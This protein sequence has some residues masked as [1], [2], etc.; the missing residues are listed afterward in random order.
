MTEPG[1]QSASDLI[2]AAQAAIPANTR[3]RLGEVILHVVG[4][5]EDVEAPRPPGNKPDDRASV[6]FSSSKSAFAV[7][8]DA[9]TDRA[10]EALLAWLEETRSVD[11]LADVDGLLI[12]YERHPSN[13]DERYTAK[14]PKWSDSTVVERLR[15]PLEKLDDEA[16][17]RLFAL[18]RTLDGRWEK[19]A[20]SCVRTWPSGAL[21]DTGILVGE[22]TK[23]LELLAPIVGRLNYL[24]RQ[25]KSSKAPA[26]ERA[27][28]RPP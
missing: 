24:V 17:D 3:S 27:P 9:V 16:R 10:A 2:A 11:Q 15:L 21:S 6:R 14:R 4:S 26:L 1:H 20:V 28:W 7:A 25:A 12:A 8:L 13:I 22:M 19:A 23:Q 5:E 18:T